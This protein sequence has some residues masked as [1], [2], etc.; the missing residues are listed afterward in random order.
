MFHVDQLYRHRGLAFELILPD[1]ATVVSE[2]PPVVRLTVEGKGGFAPTLAVTAE[3]LDPEL[4]LADW[5]T[6]SLPERALWLTAA[7]EID[8]EPVHTTA[9]PSI[10][11]LVH[12]AVG[13]HAVTL[14]QWWTAVSTRGWVVSAACA[15]AD[16]DRVANTFRC[17][18]ESFRPDGAE[19]P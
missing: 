10:R 4:D 1:G 8:R 9:G 16:Y 14:E 17:A 3:T 15:S 7:R 19:S 5:V 18:A 6:S 12:H 13:P 2:L 11:T